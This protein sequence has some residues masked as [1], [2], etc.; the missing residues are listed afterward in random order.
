[1]SNDPKVVP[2]SLR[3][4]FSWTFLGSIVASICQ[5][6]MLIAM[7]KLLDTE[8]VG[9]YALALAVAAP[10]VMFSMLQLRA[11]QVSDVHNLHTFGEYFGVRLLT[12][13][14]AGFVIG[15]V[16]FFLIGRYGIIV[17]WVIVAEGLI[18]LI[19]ATSDIAY[20]L[21]Q[22]HERMDKMAQS[23]VIRNIGGLAFM[24][25]ALFLTRNLLWGIV[26]VGVW[27]LAVLI[28]FDCRNAAQFASIRPRFD[29]KRSGAII[30]L[31]LPLGVV[32]G[33]L[34][35][36]SSIPRFFVEY[37]FGAESLGVFA[38]MAYVVVGA[39]RFIIALGQAVAPRLAKYFAFNRTAYVNLLIKVILIA[40]AMSVAAVLFGVFFGQPFLRIVYNP[41]YA[42]QPDVFVW[43][44]V[45]AGAQMINSMLGVGM[46]A[47]RKFRSQMGV[48]AAAVLVCLAACWLFLPR[49]GLKGA[50][51][52]MLAVQ[53]VLAAVSLFVIVAAL[54]TP[55]VQCSSS[56]NSEKQDIHIGS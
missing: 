37:H 35:L 51:F 48:Q 8:Q 7:A 33:L 29:L 13:V 2:L 43:L 42:Q 34:T 27:W 44:L 9:F 22:K 53:F 46:T 19:E 14:F 21:V 30:W 36:N 10:V 15:C 28:I 16:A 45:V 56:G 18:K 54:R 24:A 1:M 20:G 40:L 11:V 23:L 31:A 55:S 32:M 41:E 47:A 25:A 12:N 4:N 6:V 17:F 38:A 5:W 26:A 39:S 3:K 50:A 52:A 49:Y